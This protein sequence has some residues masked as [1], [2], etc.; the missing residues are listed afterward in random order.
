M[1]EKTYRDGCNDKK[2]VYNINRKPSRNERRTKML[3]EFRVRNYRN[4]RD[5]LYFSLETNKNYEFSQEAILNGVIKDSIV[6]G[7]N[8]SGKTNM[9]L[10]IMDITVH[11]TDKNWSNRPNLFY[12]NLYNQDDIASF[13]YRFK[14]GSDVLEYSYEKRDVEHVI[15]ENVKINGRKVLTNDMEECVIHLKGSESLNLDNWDRSISLVKYVYANTILDK[16]DEDCQNFTKFIRFVN[17]MLFI[18]STEGLKAIGSVSNGGNLIEEI[19]NLEKGVESLEAF[20]REENLPFHLVE[21]DKGE[22][23]RIYCK[24]GNKEVLFA[25]LMSSGTKSLAFLFLWYMKRENLSFIFID[26]F[27]AFYHTE[28]SVSIIRK[29]MAEK[30]IQIVFTSHNTDIISNELLRPDCYFILREN[31]IQPFCDL[32]DKALREAHN[33]QKMYKA[34]AFHE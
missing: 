29:L 22:G 17:Q 32:T 11:L 33:L 9:G 10:A 24:M 30:N 15:R 4:F 23:K 31:K 6:I 7:Y 28:L 1:V 12:S 27:D 20:L 19:C 26:E 18:S 3:T 8:A 16:N 5:E 13:M 14:F 21:R 25:P 34:G 2:T